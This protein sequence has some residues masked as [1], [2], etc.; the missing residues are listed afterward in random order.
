MT[1]NSKETECYTCKYVEHD[2]GDVEGNLKCGSTTDEMKME[3]PNYA[4]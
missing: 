3:C 4:S 1:P 2:N